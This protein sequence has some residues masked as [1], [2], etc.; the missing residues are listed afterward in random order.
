MAASAE[1]ISQL[2]RPHLP[3]HCSTSQ[4]PPSPSLRYERCPL[5][6]L[7]RQNATSQYH[8][9]Y[10]QLPQPLQQQY[11]GPPQSPSMRCPSIPL[12][13]GTPQYR[14]KTVLHRVLPQRSVPV[15]AVSLVVSLPYQ[16]P[17]P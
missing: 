8:Y 6:R 1:S 2:L 12:D 7:N 15:H 4:N 17:P 3:L 10:P 5:P 16:F 9:D 14:T 11:L 13:A